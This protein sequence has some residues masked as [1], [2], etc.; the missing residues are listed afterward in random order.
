M[1]I[2]IYPHILP[3]KY[4]AAFEKKAPSGFQ[5][6]DAINQA[7]CDLDIRFRVTDKYDDYMEVLN[8]GS[9]ALEEVVD[10]NDAKELAMIANDEMAELI[11]KHPDRFIGAIACLPMNDVDAALKEVDRAIRD[12]RFRGV[13]IYS[14]ISGFPLDHPKFMP[15]F[16]KMS[17]Y[18]LPIW[19]HPR[20]DNK[21][22]D[23]PTEDRPKYLLSTIFGWPYETSLAMARLVFSGV[24]EKYPTLKII[25][26]H[27]GGMVPFFEQ[28]IARIVDIGEILS[29]EVYPTMMPKHPIE[30]F[31]MFYGDTALLGSTPGLMCGYAFFGADHLL[32]GTD[33]PY[34]IQLGHVKIREAIRSVEEMDIPD[35]DKKKIFEDNARRLLRLPL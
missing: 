10:T 8:I 16:E 32:F 6:R 35:T 12:L 30:Y 26:H 9:P 23:Y 31:R 21:K 22:P 1:K 28:R 15:L 34:G 27:C 5:R 17:Q 11:T 20:R 7:I 14:D 4:L 29:K 13:Q 25:I 19:I 18:N 24:L 33:F 3:P 2:D